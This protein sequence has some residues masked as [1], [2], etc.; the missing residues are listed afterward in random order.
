MANAKRGSGGRKASSPA[1]QGEAPV[2]GSFVPRILEL[3][4]TV[5]F[6]GRTER[7]IGTTGVLRHLTALAVA[8]FEGPNDGTP[9]RMVL[10]QF[11][12]RAERDD[13]PGVR[14]WRA[15]YLDGSGKAFVDAAAEQQWRRF[16]RAPGT[17]DEQ[18]LRAAG[19][20]RDVASLLYTA[21]AA[22]TSGTALRLMDELNGGVGEPGPHAECRVTFT[23]GG[24]PL[25]PPVFELKIN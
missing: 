4:N 23:V 7:S 21:N 18:E 2:R 16:T 19:L 15:R 25:D 22:M 17:L 6:A 11:R 3:R 24:G 5:T 9:T 20:V 14:R 8:Y 10:F 13:R 1:K 12:T